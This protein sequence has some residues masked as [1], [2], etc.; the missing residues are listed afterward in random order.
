MAHKNKVSFT[1][2]EEPAFLKRIKEQVGYKEESTI[3]D[4][5]RPDSAP[6]DPDHEDR[7][8]REDEQPQVVVLKEGDLSQEDLNAEKKL[9]QDSDDKRKIEEGK[10]M[11][12]KPEKRKAEGLEENVAEEKVPSTQTTK[13]LKQSTEVSKHSETKAVK[14]NRLLS[15]AAEDEVDSDD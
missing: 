1:K 7:E 3:S 12:K 8:D 9:T 13:K 2:P 15:F 4:K 5:R 6:D 11:F 14:E 10:I